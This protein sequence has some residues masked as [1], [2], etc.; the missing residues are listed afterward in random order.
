MAVHALVMGF[1]GTGAHVLTY[2]KEMAVL[3]HGKKPDSIKFLQFDTIAREDWKPGETVQIAGGAGGEKVAQ[4]Q[5]ISLEPT[6]E[7]FYLE[8]STPSLKEY[9]KKYLASSASTV[10]QYPH[11]KDWLHT[12]WLG[13]HISPNKLN[14]KD[15]AAQQRQIGRFALFQNVPA[16]IQFLNGSLIELRNQ[17]G[18]ATVQVWLIGSVAGGTGAGTLLDAAFL[19]RMMET[20]LNLPGIQL[21]GVFVLPEIYQDKAGISQ[22]R[23]YSL[24]RELE[25]FQE[26]GIPNEDRYLVNGSECSSEITYDK[27][28]QQ[29]A[30]VSSRLFD[31]LFYLGT[32][33]RNDEQRTAFFT[34]IANAI[35]PYLDDNQGPPL[36]Q[37]AVNPDGASSFGAARLYMPKETY[38]ELFAWEEVKA[39]ISAITAPKEM[40]KQVIDV[41]SGSQKDRQKAAKKKIEDFLPLFKQLLQLEGKTEQ[42]ISDFA[43]NSLAPEDIVTN[44]YQLGASGLINDLKLT[45]AELQKTVLA[46]TNPYFSLEESNRE[47]INPNQ[48]VVKTYK[49][50]KAAKG[51]KEKQEISRDN[52]AE[53]LVQCTEAY[54]SDAKGSFEEGRK[55]VLKILYTFLSKKVDSLFENEFTQ[56]PQIACDHNAQEQGTIMTRLHHETSWMLLDLKS[57]FQNISFCLNAI[58]QEDG[59]YSQ[60]V[61]DAAKT[62]KEKPV[63]FFGTW[64]E[65]PQQFARESCYQYIR[66]Y[67]NRELL[68]DMQLLVKHVQARLTQWADAFKGVIQDLAVSHADRGR[69]ALLEIINTDHLKRLNGRLHR[70]AENSNALI[71][72]DPISHDVD[73]QGYR[74]VL[75][76]L[77]T[78]DGQNKSLSEQILS[79]AYWEAKVDS[80]TGPQLNLVAQ[81]G[82]D[83][84][85]VTQK[86]P[87][88]HQALYKYF[89]AVIDEKLKTQDIFDYLLYAQNKDSNLP[90]VVAQLLKARSSILLNTPAT[91]IE[92]MNWVYQAPQD[93]QKQALASAL[94]V[95][96]NG[97]STPATLHSDP[98]ALTLLRLC[99]PNT[100]QVTNLSECKNAYMKDQMEEK[101]GQD[102]H[103]NA[104]LRA[105]VYHPFRAELEA[106]NIERYYYHRQL[107]EVID[108]EKLISPRICRLLEH[109]DMMRT[110]VRCIATKVIERNDELQ[111]WFFHNSVVKKDKILDIPLSTSD[112]PTADVMTAAVTFVLRQL[113]A[114]Q[115][116]RVKIELIH[117]EKSVIKFAQ[118]AGTNVND[119]VQDFV[120]HPSEQDSEQLDNFLEK[121]SN[122]VSEREKQNL[123]MIFQF[124]GDKNRRTHLGD[125]N[126]LP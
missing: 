60:Q 126:D 21:S 39:L 120:G 122:T 86:L 108:S 110:F 115:N 12:S 36:L 19:T 98:N 107:Q 40:D 35:D 89:R 64:V 70:L 84:N 119:M 78:V 57:I 56:N 105:Q 28:G 49:E 10:N 99:F 81:W 71:S 67:Q 74:D 50:N 72:C 37:Q 104:L 90:Q 77:A 32:P 45:P 80:K 118:E 85:H 75:H 26:I 17:A 82:N 33:C 16:I 42:E 46:Y 24:F 53:T 25:R 29:H 9:V 13:K 8:D 66:W 113:E 93:P 15:G 88:F 68:K 18:T 22:A 51:P 114:K 52:F 44:W 92:T 7:Y 27:T 38:A 96:L 5:E 117:A 94:Q 76:R 116:S 65:E 54:T 1:G 95:A 102:K 63:K 4:G 101:N 79:Q 3:K 91:Q 106:W 112:Q 83:Q 87:Q 31:N 62:L 55:Q 48:I 103:D 109:P 11:L 2:L 23:A 30:C 125:R 124:Y 41:Y 20:H 121:H 123:K 97:A 34:S 43:R 6:S 73:M 69:R 100:D 58:K 111:I 61:V 47:K 59:K 14:I